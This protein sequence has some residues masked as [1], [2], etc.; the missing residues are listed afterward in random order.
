M[1]KKVGTE[2]W[3][4]KRKQEHL[5]MKE[6]RYYIFCEGEQTEPNYFDGFKKLIENNPVY[7]DMVLIEIE[8]C[9]ADTMR[10]PCRYPESD[11]NF[12]FT[13]K[14]VL[15]LSV[16][17]CFLGERCPGGDFHQS[18]ARNGEKVQSKTRLLSSDR[19][20]SPQQPK[21]RRLW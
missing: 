15:G 13:T 19:I 11:S 20:F 1:P 3:R 7:R 17:K 14:A 2:N 9:G 4:K 18:Q 16:V 12:H 6:F 21:I 5:E 8:P 10:V